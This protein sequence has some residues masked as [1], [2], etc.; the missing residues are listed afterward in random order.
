MEE[1][2]SALRFVPAAPAFLDRL[3]KFAELLARWGARMN[4]TARPDDPDEVAFHMTD[5]LMSAVIAGRTEPSPLAGGF[6]PG[7]RVL[8]LGSGAGFPGLVLAAATTASFTLVE[9]RRRRSSFLRVVIAEAGIT[10]TTVEN[11]TVEAARVHDLH[12]LH[13]FDVVTARAFGK[14]AEF[15]RIA[16]AALRP[17]G[18]AVLYANPSQQLALDTARTQGF[19]AYDRI[20]Y[21]ARRGGSSV[22]RMLAVW[23]KA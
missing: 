11:T 21:Q 6:D 2:L 15:Y 23:R 13:D 14:P 10:N 20:A 5:S 18:V 4:L 8:D 3:G 22:S 17:G 7:R 1:Q 12:R 16:A 19:S 9:S